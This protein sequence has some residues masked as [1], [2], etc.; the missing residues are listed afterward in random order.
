MNKKLGIV[1]QARLLS[2]RL[3]GKVLSPFAKSNILSIQLNALKKSIGANMPLIVATTTHKVDD[4][5]VRF[6]EEENVQCFRGSQDDVLGRF[7]ECGNSFQLDSMVR[8]CADNPF[9]LPDH[10]GILIDHWRTTYDYISFKDSE[11]V[12]AIRT[13]WGLFGEVVSL[14]SLKKAYSETEGHPKEGFYREHV[15]NYIY[16]HPEKFSVKLFD[17]PTVIKYRRD[18]RYTIDTQEDFFNMQRLYK[19][20]VSQ[21]E[22]FSLKSIIKI[23]D[24]H[25]EIKEIM[26]ENIRKFSK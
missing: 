3:P 22:D 2:S 11:N 1:I 19:I 23:T 13:H 6:C 14:K 4:D 9:F 15:T 8:V 24:K 18:L 12:P 21:D 5:I 26:A 17:A 7:I 10:L 25:P 16:A 20:I